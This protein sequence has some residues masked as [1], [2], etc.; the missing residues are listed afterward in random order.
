MCS[1][2]AQQKLS[3]GPFQLTRGEQQQPTVAGGGDNLRRHTRA[4][5]LGIL[6][7]P[8]EFQGHH[9]AAAAHVHDGVGLRQ[10]HQALSMHTPIAGSTWHV[11]GLWDNS[12]GGVLVITH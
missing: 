12:E 3:H 9:E 7:R 6:V 10:C 4:G 1:P 5:T 11:R 2:N 8:P